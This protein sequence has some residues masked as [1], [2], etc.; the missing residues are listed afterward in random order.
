MT[1]RALLL[2][3]LL[4]A[5]AAGAGPTPAPVRAEIDGLMAELRAGACRFQRNGS[6][7]GL[8]EAQKVLT[9]KLQKLEDQTTLT[10]T[11]D[12]IDQ[13]ATRSSSTGQA[14]QVQ[15]GQGPI[16]PAGAWLY[17]ALKRLRAAQRR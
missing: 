8:D 13:A 16:E 15:C 6:W 1:R 2:P 14:Y 17:A 4:L 12:F 7:H 9:Y 3:A 5:T 11:E 10:R